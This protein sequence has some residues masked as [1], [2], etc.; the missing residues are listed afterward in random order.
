[1]QT[2]RVAIAG[3]GLSGLYAAYLL[4]Q[5]G[6][7]DYV[8]LEARN[9]LGGRIETY[10]VTD[11]LAADTAY[12]SNSIDRFDLGPTWYWPLIQPQLDRLI[13][14]LGLACFEQHETGDM[15]VERSQ[16]T[17]PIRTPGYLYSP[18][19]MRLMGGMSSLIEALRS[20]LDST[21]IIT[22]QKVRRL[23]HTGHY[24]ELECEVASGQVTPFRVEHVLLAMPPRL[25]EQSIEFTPALPQALTEQ[26]RAT[27]T[28]MAPHAKYIAIYE[29]P[30]WREQRLS[31]E[32]RSVVGPLNEIHDAS[33]P[34]G[35]AALFGFFGVPASVRKGVPIDVMRSHCRAQLK[36]LFGPQAETPKAEII[37]DWALDPYIATVA[38]LSSTDHHAEAPPASAAA[39]PWS[40]RLSGIASEWSPQFPG[41]VAGAIEAASLGVQELLSD[42]HHIPSKRQ[43][44]I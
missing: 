33:M 6:I 27:A 21:R 16:N 42:S 2:A 18:V 5:N 12:A 37:K 39:G 19:S 7:K 11:Q 28:W 38:D 44:S 29:S 20:K 1:M 23:R 4:E 43:F 9:T 8:L 10:S 22:G 32:A 3:G 40:K 17:H 13:R 15:L 41:Y 35:S 25:V 36:R 14:D 30:F 26:W 24:V 34:G 31:G